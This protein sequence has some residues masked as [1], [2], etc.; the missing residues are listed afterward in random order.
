MYDSPLYFQSS[1]FV[2]FFFIGYCNHCVI[3]IKEFVVCDES[4]IYYAFVVSISSV[5]SKEH[6]TEYKAGF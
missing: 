6:T 1:S 3:I 2:K 5:L 4:G